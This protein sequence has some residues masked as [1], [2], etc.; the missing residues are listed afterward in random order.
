MATPAREAFR[1]E[2]RA[3]QEAY[4]E[5]RRGVRRGLLGEGYV[6]GP[7]LQHTVQQELRTRGA[8]AA[9][10]PTAVPPAGVTRPVPV[11]PK[12]IIP[13]GETPFRTPYRPSLEERRGQ[14]REF[15]AEGL[16][17]Q[18]L[19]GAMQA[20]RGQTREERRPFAREDVAQ[21]LPEPVGQFLNAPEFMNRLLAGEEPYPPLQTLTGVRAA[22]RL[23]GY[24][25]P[26][27]Q[28]QQSLLST[29][30][31]ENAGVDLQRGLS[32]TLPDL[33]AYARERLAESGL[34]PE[35]ESA[36]RLRQRG[37]V[38]SAYRQATTDEGT[39]LAQAGIDP[40]SGVAAQRGLQ[41]QRARERGLADVEAGITE[42]E[43]GRKA[44]IESLGGA[45]AGLEE[46]GRRFDVLTPLERQQQVENRLMDLSNLSERQRIEDLLYGEGMRQARLSREAARKAAEEL[47]P[48]ALEITGSVLGGL[49]GGL[50]AGGGR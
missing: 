20:W 18:K 49:F 21:F 37:P 22:R 28:L 9:P 46:A 30:G 15:K 32:P 41:L 5:E 17:G 10:P 8:T 19:K 16:R 40:R 42:A 4:R 36:I 14:R 29:L 1:A 47:E 6:P 34:T 27:E 44:Q 35:E 25:V 48:G 50:G 39:R 13:P 23:L 3:P 7:A 24:D 31:A 45:V 12:G 26:Q 2:K 43:L 33:S 38:E 11:G